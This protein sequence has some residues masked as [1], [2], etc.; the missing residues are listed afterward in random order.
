MQD[1]TDHVSPIFGLNFMMDANI[2]TTERETYSLISAFAT[3]GGF[4][5]LI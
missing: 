4:A 1:V 5:G 3:I 2:K